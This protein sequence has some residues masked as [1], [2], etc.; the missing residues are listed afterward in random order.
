MH[1][2]EHTH[3]FLV[4]VMSSTIHGAFGHS[5][6][7]SIGANLLLEGYGRPSE[8]GIPK[9]EVQTLLKALVHTRGP[10]AV[11]GVIPDANLQVLLAHAGC[12][13]SGA[14]PNA[15]AGGGLERFSNGSDGDHLASANPFGSMIL[16]DGASIASTSSNLN[17]GY[18]NVTAIVTAIDYYMDKHADNT[19]I[20]LVP[21][22]WFVPRPTGDQ[23]DHVKLRQKLR[24]LQETGI[25]FTAPEEGKCSL[26]PIASWALLD[27]DHPAILV[28]NDANLTT[29]CREAATHSLELMAAMRDWLKL[30]ICPFSFKTTGGNQLFEPSPSFHMPRLHMGLGGVAFENGAADSGNGGTTLHGQ[31]RSH[32]QSLLTSSVEDL[33]QEAWRQQQVIDEI[34]NGIELPAVAAARAD[35]LDLLANRIDQIG[36]KS[37]EAWNFDDEKSAWDV[38]NKVIF[39]CKQ[40]QNASCGVFD[41]DAVIPSDLEDFPEMMEHCAKQLRATQAYGPHLPD[42]LVLEV[43]KRFTEAAKAVDAKRK[44]ERERMRQRLSKGKMLTDATLGM[45]LYGDEESD[46]PE[47]T[48]TIRWTDEVN[49]GEV[50]HDQTMWRKH[51]HRLRSLYEHH[52]PRPTRMLD[53][54]NLMLTRIFSMA[55]RYDCLSKTKSAYQAALP[56]KLMQ[57]LSTKLGVNHECFASPLNHYFPSYCSVFHDTD[58]YFGSKGSFYSYAPAEGVYECNPPFDNASV[59]A[60]FLRIGALLAASD[61]VR[62]GQAARPLSFVFV[63]PCMDFNP[64]LK[65]AHNAVKRF[66]TRTVVAEVNRHVYRVG[67]QHRRTGHGQGD[68]FWRPEKASRIYFFQNSTGRHAHPITEELVNDILHDFDY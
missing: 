31:L 2:R 3:L 55:L 48:V 47:A 23:P 39:F 8:L 30:W 42:D 29:G 12:C 37:S 9:S 24:N 28:S 15:R 13:S 6:D 22:H 7:E 4:D 51:F 63:I 16:L 36:R 56:H 25:V 34:L 44:A 59:Q 60:A 49:G 53:H 26:P 58:H 46:D 20:C 41:H 21:A 17:G 66:E 38:L 67:L 64:Q 57:R 68:N 14:S 33:A 61:M 19:V 50:V 43:V 27:C 11:R 62:Q 18:L 54:R 52:A 40:D 10:A 65:E 32:F 45:R 5:E 1:A 35:Q